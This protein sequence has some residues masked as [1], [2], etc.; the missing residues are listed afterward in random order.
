MAADDAEVSAGGDEAAEHP[1]AAV[2]DRPILTPLEGGSDEYTGEQLAGEMF[3]LI[4]RRL[5]LIAPGDHVGETIR[6]LVPALGAALGRPRL[7]PVE[8]RRATP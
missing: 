7:L 3:D 4:R 2:S 6:R 5:P 8:E 1:G